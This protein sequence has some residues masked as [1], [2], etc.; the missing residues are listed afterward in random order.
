MKFAGKKMTPSIKN[1]RRAR[2]ASGFT[3]VE[4]LAAMLFMAIVIPAA[5]QGI[6][7]ANRAG[8]IA[9]R[10]TM[11]AQ[12]ADTYLTE[13]VI[14]EQWQTMNPSG[15]FPGVHSKYQWR[16]NQRNWDI[17]PMI[18]LELEVLFTVQGREYIVRT[19]TLVEEPEA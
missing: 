14:T 9:E 6:T 16:L 4:V 7:L 19:S 17:D 12:L 3:F 8:V 15:A 11:A 5:V 10:K 13:L 1:A 2:E 18:Y